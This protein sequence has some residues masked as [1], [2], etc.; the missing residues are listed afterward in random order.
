MADAP[1]VFLSYSHDSVEHAARVLALADALCDGGID[2]ILDRYVHP[3]PAEGWPRWMDRNLD[4]AQFVLMVCTATYRRRV[5]GQEEPGK[6]L[7]VDWEGN[8][9]YNAVYHRIR[10]NQPSGSR[11]IPLLLPDS[12][13]A[14]IPGPVQGHSYYRIT[15]FDLSDAGFEALYR[16]LTDQPATLK[17]DLGALVILPPKSRPQPSPGPQPPSG[18][19]VVGS[20]IGTGNTVNARDINVSLNQGAMS[21]TVDRIADE[22][23]D[24]LRPLMGDRDQR[25]ARL[26]WAFAGHH[27]LIDQIS[28]DGDTSTFLLLLFKKLREYGEIEVGKPAVCVS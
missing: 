20:A 27:G 15:A 25:K 22:F 3:A 26:D 7:G 16:H 4:A 24:V 11:F 9:I 10:N 8:L 19:N 18:G 17:P 5:M 12:E 13:P 2:V 6:G 28:V 23:R 14:H 1:R 21:P